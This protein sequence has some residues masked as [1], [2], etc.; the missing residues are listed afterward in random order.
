MSKNRSPGDGGG[1]EARPA[2]RLD[3]PSPG[4]RQQQLVAVLAGPA[5]LELDAGLLADALERLA[6]SCPRAAAA[7]GARS[8][9]E[10]LERRD[11]ALLSAPGAGG[12]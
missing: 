2:F 7:S 9:A 8:V 4:C 6:R 10:R 12:P 1:S 11:A 3:A 5:S